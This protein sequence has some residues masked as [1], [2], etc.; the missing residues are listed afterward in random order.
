M[1]ANASQEH[2]RKLNQQLIQKDNLIRLLQMR[3]DATKKSGVETPG[4]GSAEQEEQLR[5]ANERISELSGECRALESELSAL[6]SRGAAAPSPGGDA[7]E[8]V[9]SL[10]AECENLHDQMSHLRKEFDRTRR[11][12]EERAAEIARL[13]DGAQERARGGA[14]AGDA[15]GQSIA[16][17]DIARL[18]RKLDEFHRKGDNV[19]EIRSMLGLIR[20]ELVL[21]IDR[22]DV[23]LERLR[24]ELRK[25]EPLKALAESAEERARRAED[26]LS[27]ARLEA[28]LDG[29]AE[30]ER[31]PLVYNLVQMLD[32]LQSAN[33]RPE[34]AADA[35]RAAR[36]ALARIETL[37]QKLA[38]DLRIERVPTIG[39]PYDPNAHEAVEFVRSR[40][41]EDD[42]V[43]DEVRRGF[44]QGGR[45]LRP[46]QVRVVKNRQKCVSC[47]N[48]VRAGSLFCDSCG[49]RLESAGAPVA[50][51]RATAEMYFNTARIFEEKGVADKAREYFQ[52]AVA[53]E[54]SNARFVLSLGRALELSGDY[55]GAIDC[56]RQIPET[57]ALRE[58]AEDRI[59]RILVK[60]SIVDG[61]RQLT[62]S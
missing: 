25:A 41:H 22:R 26:R 21:E 33:D 28:S 23:E 13:R 2:V 54:P 55:A 49:T 8:R 10:E 57:E 7:D 46:A 47:G 14:P 48:V 35:G 32:E 37:V 59:R 38:K 56:L 29:A 4:A 27:T 58:S 9:A 17:L 11:E 42:T 61:L 62:A 5:R 60:K 50:D 51:L 15:A 44:R 30:G 24:A 39:E 16:D 12:S 1:D 3:L 6:R 31:I 45:V 52:Q 34:T 53:L 18:E 36:T 20:S 43:I 40:D 19:E